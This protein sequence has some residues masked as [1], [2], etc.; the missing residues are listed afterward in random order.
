MCRLLCN[1]SIYTPFAFAHFVQD[2]M[3]I[4]DNRDGAFVMLSGGCEAPEV[5][6]SK[7]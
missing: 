3:F 2:D 6:A 7:W 5:E 1:L 4:Q